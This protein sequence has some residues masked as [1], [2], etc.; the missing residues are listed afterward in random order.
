[1]AKISYPVKP[2]EVLTLN[3]GMDFLF[4]NTDKKSKNKRFVSHNS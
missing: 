2:K 3:T 4:T 1:M